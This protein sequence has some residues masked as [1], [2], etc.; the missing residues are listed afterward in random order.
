MSEMKNSSCG[1]DQEDPEAPVKNR[2]FSEFM[3][4]HFT[5]LTAQVDSIDNRVGKLEKGLI[6]LKGQAIV[7]VPLSLAILAIVI[8]VAF[9][10]GGN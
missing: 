3:H 2:V 1:C 4:N 10:V 7:V 6:F 8:A 9:K 5:H